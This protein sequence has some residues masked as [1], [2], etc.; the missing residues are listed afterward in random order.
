MTIINPDGTRVDKGLQDY[1]HDQVVTFDKPGNYTSLPAASGDEG[2]VT[3][4]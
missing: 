2:G 3:V 4:K 1:H